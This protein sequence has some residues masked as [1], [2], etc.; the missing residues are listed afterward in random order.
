MDDDRTYIDSVASCLL[1]KA[2][3]QQFLSGEEIIKFFEDNNIELKIKTVDAMAYKC[4]SIMVP[5]NDPE[6]FICQ[7]CG[8]YSIMKFTNLYEHNSVCY[9]CSVGINECYHKI[10]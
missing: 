7:C 2:R 8:I 1:D 6:L 3:L 10:K 9:D 5:I 4:R